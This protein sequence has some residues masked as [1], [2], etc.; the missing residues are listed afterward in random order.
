MMAP[1]FD[2]LRRLL[3]VLADCGFCASAK[4]AAT[5]GIPSMRIIAVLPSHSYARKTARKRLSSS[6]RPPPGG[7]IGSHQANHPPP[8]EAALK[9]AAPPVSPQS[10][11]LLI[12]STLDRF[13]RDHWCDPR[14]SFP[15]T[16]NS[17]GRTQT[18]G[19]GGTERQPPDLLRCFL[20]SRA[21]GGPG[22]WVVWAVPLATSL[23]FRLLLNC[24]PLRL[25]A[26]PVRILRSC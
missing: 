24:R 18:R 1:I 2:V 9:V 7:R 13:S 20:R 14:P 10:G 4:R 3:R 6:G 16:G 22:R 11:R 23:E 12:T 15:P 8:L 19:G 17:G 25:L 21:E 26:M 5:I